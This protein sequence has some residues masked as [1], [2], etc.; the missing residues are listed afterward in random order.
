MINGQEC[1][2]IKVTAYILT[3]STAVYGLSSPCTV[4]MSNLARYRHRKAKAV[5]PPANKYTANKA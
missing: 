4:N 3:S 2:G 1:C 5:S